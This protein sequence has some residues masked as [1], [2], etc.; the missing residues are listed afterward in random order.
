MNAYKSRLENYRLRDPERVWIKNSDIDIATSNPIGFLHFVKISP[1]P[2]EKIP[3]H[4]KKEIEKQAV[5]KVLA[6]EKAEGRIPFLMPET[7]H[8]DIKSIL[9]ST[10]EIRLIEVKG[11]KG[12]EIYAELTEDEV[13]IAAKEKERYWLYI[14]YDIGSGQPKILRFQNPLE[15]MDLQVLERIQKRYI[16]RPKT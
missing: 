2:L 14:V 9:P 3:E 10:G 8:Y 6:D 16:L 1:K 7:E 13:E 12:L 5:E 11:H 15:T 4:V